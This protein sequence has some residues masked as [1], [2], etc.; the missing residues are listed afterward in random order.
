MHTYIPPLLALLNTNSKLCSN[1]TELSS[2]LVG[3]AWV[4]DDCLR[5]QLLEQCHH[6]RLSPL[7]ASLVGVGFESVE[8]WLSSTGNLPKIE[9]VCV[10]EGV[11]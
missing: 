4:Q 2:Y 11:T 3:G 8:I 10:R 5:R 6:L 1:D 9:R 7:L